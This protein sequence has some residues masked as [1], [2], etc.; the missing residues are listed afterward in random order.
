MMKLDEGLETGMR[1]HLL[2]LVG[3]LPLLLLS[4]EV[5][6]WAA[7]G[8]AHQLEISPLIVGLT[9]IAVGTSLP[10]LVVVLA[11]SMRGETDLAIGNI[12]GSNIFNLLAVLAIPGLV[13]PTGLETVVL[14]RDYL[15]ML[16]MTLLL[17]LFAYGIGKKARITRVE[18][19]FIFSGWIV[20]LW[21]IYQAS[22][23]P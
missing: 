8:I 2:F 12:V 20:Y 13:M 17:L 5:L 18:G 23:S 3:S 1:K 9:V 10:E 15:M 19:T 22:V 21:V 4:A 16:I 11:S 14:T 6:V 7:T